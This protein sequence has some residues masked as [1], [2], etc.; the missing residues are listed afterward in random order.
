MTLE[1]DS[2]TQFA[3]KWDSLSSIM[4]PKPT[5]GTD[6][7]ADS[8][9]RLP[10]VVVSREDIHYKYGSGQLA[11]AAK[12]PKGVILLPG[13]YVCVRTYALCVPMHTCVQLIL[14]CLRH[15]GKMKYIKLIN[16]IC[17]TQ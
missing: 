6:T 8:G 1:I 13:E 12:Y 17:R 15:H 14:D 9:D 5:E 3:Q 11:L 7:Q 10:Y 4:V 16:Q 2:Q